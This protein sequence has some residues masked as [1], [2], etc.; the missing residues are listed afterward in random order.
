LA[1]GL[2]GAEA[3]PS[4][5][6]RR[7]TLGAGSFPSAK[8]GVDVPADFYESLGHDAGTLVRQAWARLGGAGKSQDAKLRA[9][10]PD[11]LGEVS[12]PLETSEA[13]GFCGKRRL[14]RHL[15]IREAP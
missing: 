9:R 13:T 12:I 14:L 2:E 1:V 3:L 8:P 15:T 10:L 11:A 5:T 7:F 6:G 4:L